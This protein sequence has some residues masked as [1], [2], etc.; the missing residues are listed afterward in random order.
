MQRRW[1]VTHRADQ[2]RA[3]PL[4]RLESPEL[5]SDSQGRPQPQSIA[6]LAGDV[7]FAQALALLAGT[8]D[9][10]LVAQL[11]AL[12]K[13]EAAPHVAAA[14]DTETGLRPTGSVPPKRVGD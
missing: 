10:S 13:D 3:A 5:W 6:Q 4:D 14:R 2:E 1:A 12:V 9:Y 7:D 8:P 11:T